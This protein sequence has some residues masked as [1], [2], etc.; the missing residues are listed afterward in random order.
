MVEHP[1]GKVERLGFKDVRFEIDATGAAAVRTM[2]GARQFPLGLFRFDA[3]IYEVESVDQF[4]DLRAFDTLGFLHIHHRG[5]QYIQNTAC[6]ARY[7]T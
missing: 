5:R 3:S 7:N 1:G 2:E 4:L 6:F